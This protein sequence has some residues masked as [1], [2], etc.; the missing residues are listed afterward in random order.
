MNWFAAIICEI[1]GTLI[2]LCII[3][4]LGLF[5]YLFITFLMVMCLPLKIDVINRYIINRL[6]NSNDK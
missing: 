1:F 4:P 2:Y 6:S 5:I 3:F